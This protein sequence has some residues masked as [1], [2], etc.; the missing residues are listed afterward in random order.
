MKFWGFLPGLAA[1][2]L[3]LAAI[4]LTGQSAAPPP[5]TLLR[6]RNLGKAFYENPTTQ[7]QAV[8]QF[9]RALELNPKSTA[10]RLNYGLA[11]LRAGRSAE[12][13]AE[14]EAVQ[15][16][17]PSLPHTWFNLGI[18]YKKRGETARAIQQ[19]EQMAK[20][21]PGEPITHY[22]LGVLFKADGKQK[23][24]NAKFTLAARLDP[25]FAAPH[26]Q[27]FNFYRQSGDQTHAR[28]ELALFQDLKNRHEES[29]AGNED[30]EWCS[31]SE[32]YD[33][34]DAALSAAPAPPAALS[35][36]ST[37][38]PGKFPAANTSLHVIDL[39][40][41]GSSDL[42]VVS[43]TGM[44]VFR[45]GLTPVPQPALASVTGILAAIPGDYDNDGLVDLCVLTTT[46][47][48]LFHN[49][50]T[51]FQESSINLPAGRYETAVWL[52][53]DHDY[54]LDL[55]LLGATTTLLRNQ[56]P[57][58]FAERT[59]DIPFV[60]GK[61][62]SAA[63]TRIIPDTKSHDLVITYADR[64]AVLYK[65]RLG[66]KYEP[67]SLA[68]VPSGATA[69]LSADLDNDSFPDLIWSSG[70]A[71]NRDGAVT[72][73]PWQPRGSFALADLESRGLLDVLASDGFYR[74]NAQGRFTATQNATGLPSGSITLAAA[75]F[76][77][78]GRTDLAL[79]LPDGTLHRCLNRTSLRSNWSR[80]HLNGVKNLKLAP[81]AEVEIKAGALY[82][83]LFYR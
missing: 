28:A 54:D 49:T 50:R 77:A 22:N 70:A 9:K 23:E 5:E 14:L 68:A 13:I 56:L 60:T 24:A 74:N 82:Q 83:K 80:I 69:L 26:F 25:N 7:A 4:A 39:D 41:T 32:V 81:G 20:L 78:D 45:K 18:E 51:G 40:G 72:S 35:F 12:G 65:D 36:A 10:D 19:L 31:Y 66:G 33:P 46:G 53:Y 6:L 11:L 44:T 71:L 76:D 52:D 55:L 27:L 1:T 30:V 2:A 17:D 61:A 37:A 79:L 8:D 58:G 3:V 42:L 15:K 62:L 43:T 67:S 16:I 38:L 29:G 64:P 48:I 21:V 59:A 75:D 63:V 47:P 34:I 73:V 57:Q